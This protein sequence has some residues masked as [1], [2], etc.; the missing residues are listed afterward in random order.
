[1]W[2]WRFSFIVLIFIFKVMT[3]FSQSSHSNNS[4]AIK[5]RRL[6]L[7]SADVVSNIT[8]SLATSGWSGVSSISACA[9][10]TLTMCHRVRGF[11][12]AP[13]S[14]Q[15]T[16]VLWLHQ[17][18][19][20][21]IVPAG[22]E[23]GHPGIMYLFNQADGFCQDGFEAW[24]YDNEGRFVCLLEFTFLSS[25]HNATIECNNLGGYLASVR[26]AEKLAIVEQIYNGTSL[27]LGMDDIGKEGVF[28]WQ[29]DGQT[30]TDAE[31][32]ATFKNDFNNYYG[33]QDCLQY[34]NK[35]YGLNDWECDDNLRALCETP[36]LSGVC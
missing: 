23:D 10:V 28:I 35:A 15:C 16:P 30:L 29:E 21:I 7:V 36:P 32:R 24:N 34:K 18:S 8:Y 33:G 26:T 12:Y 11:L 4:L 3:G 31:F 14:E 25:Y 2:T 17:G 13:G 22:T 9:R 1:M 20:G 19:G 5:T 27:W 6:S